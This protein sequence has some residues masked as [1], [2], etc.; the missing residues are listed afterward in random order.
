[1]TSNITKLF[2]FCYIWKEVYDP[3]S[4]IKRLS[5]ICEGYTNNEILSNSFFQEFETE[6]KDLIKGLNNGL[7]TTS[8]SFRKKTKRLNELIEKE[9][10]RLEKLLN[11]LNKSI[12]LNL[13][14]DQQSIENFTL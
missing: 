5:L 11:P 8:Q 14:N 10:K 7:N 6:S 2:I 3:N 13:K 9:I 4:I 12:I 1:M